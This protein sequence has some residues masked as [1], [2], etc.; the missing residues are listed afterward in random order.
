V[1]ELDALRTRQEFVDV[2]ERRII[3]TTPA[4]RR[5]FEGLMKWTGAAK[6]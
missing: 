4:E 5:Q 1:A 6:R 3:A 2:V